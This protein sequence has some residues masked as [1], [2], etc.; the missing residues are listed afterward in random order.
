MEDWISDEEPKAQPEPSRGGGSGGGKTRIGAGNDGE[1]DPG[2][3]IVFAQEETRRLGFNSVGT[4]HI[5]IGLIRCRSGI[6]P[7]VLSDL[8]VTVE[9][10]RA[11]VESITGRGSGFATK[12][13]PFTP[14]ARLVLQLAWEE[15]RDLG[16]NYVGSEHLLL[17]IVKEGNG[18]ASRVLEKFKIDGALVR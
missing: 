16:H 17:G 4:E 14:R 11:K 1:S 10:A 8:G 3:I 13:M 12:E 7:G 2:S 9:A 15:A 6:A 5:L 18:V